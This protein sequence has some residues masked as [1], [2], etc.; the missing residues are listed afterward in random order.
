MR[1]YLISFFLLVGEVLS[2]VCNPLL[3]QEPKIFKP[4]GE[5]LTFPWTGGLDACQFGTMDL[6]GD[7]VSD[8][9]AFDRRGNRLLCFLNEGMEGEIAYQF[10][11]QYTRFFPELFEWVVFL[12]Y[13][14]DGFEDI[15]TYSPGWAGIRVF[16]HLGTTPPSFDLMVSPYLTSLQGGGYVNI[17]STNADYPA[18]LDIDEDGDVDILTFWA[19]GSYIELHLNQSIEKYGHPD[20]LDFK[21]TDFCWGRVAE[22]EENNILYLDSCLFNRE[23]IFAKEGFRHRGATMLVTDFTGNGLPDMLLSDVDYSGFTLLQNGGTIDNAF[24]VSQDTAFPSYDVPARIFSMPVAAYIDVNNDGLKD[25]LVSPFDPNPQVTENLNSIWLYLNEGSIDQPVFRL[26]TKNFLQNQTIDHGSGAYP[27]L[28]DINGDSK[29]DLIVGNIGQYVRSWY[30]A[31]TLH[32]EYISKL[33]YYENIGDDSQVIFQLMDHDFAG[34]SILKLNGLTPA[35]ADLNG[36]GLPDMLVGNEEGR[37]IL[38][39]Q[40]SNGAWQIK[41]IFY[42]DIDVGSWSAPQLFDLDGDG[43]VDLLIGGRNGKISYY[44][45]FETK[46]EISFEY[47]T[48]YLGYVNV[49][50]FSLSYDGFSVPCFFHTN[51]GNLML[52]VGSEQGKIFLFDQ[53]WG[54]I[55]GSFRETNDW[56]MVLDTSLTNLDVGIRSAG[57]VGQ[58]SAKS[59]LQLIAGNFSGGL[60]LFNG[61]ATVAPGLFEK[62]ALQFEILPNPANESVLISTKDILERKISIQLF[63]IEGKLLQKKEI[64]SSL[65]ST[66]IDI[67]FL[68]KGVYVISLQSDDMK[69]VQRFIKF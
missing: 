61:D 55:D 19:L 50:D 21:K 14:N 56:N 51:E 4:S 37:L 67:S 8:L 32:S 1:I 20:S 13:D 39:E 49:T 63:S 62:T 18:I 35:F 24:I 5:L 25:L 16:R 58:I 33:A 45:G 59:T 30:I 28:F 15:F 42:Q 31:N 41:S 29:K 64:E 9:L 11:P 54:N 68:P 12:D 6:N 2:Y 66:R 53:I 27:V 47:V 17:I 34:L 52:S 36:D 60:Q 38:V 57:F 3:A 23:Q 43:I 46:G 44:K 22:N 7:G 48:D 40:I 10:A 69:G 26:Y 65:I